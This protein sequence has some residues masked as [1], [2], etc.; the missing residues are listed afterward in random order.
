MRSSAGVRAYNTNEWMNNHYDKLMRYV[1]DGGN[2]IVQYNTSNNAGPVRA[3]IGPYN[4]DISRERVTDENAPII[5]LTPQHPVLNFPN[6]IDSDDFK[7]WVQERSIYHATNWDR[8]NLSRFFPCMI[9]AKH[10]IKAA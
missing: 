9:L 7:G 8:E 2:L 5:F 3:K 4:F 1:N 6:T 10:R